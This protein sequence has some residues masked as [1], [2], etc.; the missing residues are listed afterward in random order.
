ML[1]ISFVVGFVDVVSFVVG[2]VVGFVDV[3][4][5]LSN[6]QLAPGTCN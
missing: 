6:V 3:C 2:L 5:L 4:W 1:L